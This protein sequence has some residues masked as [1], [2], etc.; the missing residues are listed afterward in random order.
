MSNWEERDRRRPNR[1]EAHVSAQPR[2]ER[3]RRRERPPGLPAAAA[4]DAGLRQVASL[5][6]YDAQAVVSLTPEDGGWVVGVEVVEDQRVPRSA[7]LLALYEAKI[8][9]SGELT[10]Y[11]RKRRYAR[12]SSDAGET[13]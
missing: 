1:S 13:P 6:G 10:G 9:H 7:D 11:S 4:A 3:P 8:D 2:E 12:G 5:T